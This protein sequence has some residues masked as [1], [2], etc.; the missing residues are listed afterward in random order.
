MYGQ[1]MA[2]CVPCMEIRCAA[3][4]TVG[5]IGEDRLI[6]CANLLLTLTLT[7]CGSA[8]VWR[9]MAHV[10]RPRQ[11]R[12]PICGVWK[13]NLSKRGNSKQCWYPVTSC[14]FPIADQL[15]EA[16]AAVPCN[17]HICPKCYKRARRRSQPPHRDALDELT[18]A[19]EEQ[20]HRE[21]LTSFPSSTP[22]IP[23]PLP[24]AQPVSD[25]PAR[26]QSET[27]SYDNITAA[28]HSYSTPVKQSRHTQ[29]SP[30]RLYSM[31]QKAKMVSQ[32][33]QATTTLE[34]QA[35]K[36]E[37]RAE[38]IDGDVIRKWKEILAENNSRH[39]VYRAPQHKRKLKGGCLPDLH[40]EHETL[41]DEWVMSRRQ[42]LLQVRVCDVQM[43]ARS[44]F[45]HIVGMADPSKAETSG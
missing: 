40:E 15:D 27:I 38:Q 25:S 43:Y 12:C 5:G 28:Q 20:Q 7:R 8:V 37:W 9:S 33:D 30:R 26:S 1:C 32:W 45:P 18:A 4:A 35:L 6:S 42:R 13:G 11:S 34:K 39:K 22:L 16:L 19:L 41:I 14:L 44:K 3:A 2:M 31:A 21:P 17:D 10:S 23:P 36:R 29:L 24:P